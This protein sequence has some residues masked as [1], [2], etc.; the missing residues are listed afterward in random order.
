MR[1]GDRGHIAT[2]TL[3]SV[4]AETA[5]CRQ[6]RR[7]KSRIDLIVILPAFP[8]LKSQ[9]TEAEALIYY[10]ESQYDSMLAFLSP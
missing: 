4:D 9:F 2:G 8:C 10:D 1:D 5:V 3:F 7:A 6:N